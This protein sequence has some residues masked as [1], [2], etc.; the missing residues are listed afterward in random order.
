[1]WV[2]PIHQSRNNNPLYCQSGESRPLQIF[3]QSLRDEG[4]KFLFKGWTP[5]FIRLAPNTILLFVFFEVRFCSQLNT[6]FSRTFVE[7]SAIE[8]ITD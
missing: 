1:M 8:E 7:F 6:F 5:A 3:R 4:V 2:R